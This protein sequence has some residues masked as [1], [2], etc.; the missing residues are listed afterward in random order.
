MNSNTL[1]E[2]PGFRLVEEPEKSTPPSRP[3][4]RRR[5]W[6]GLIWGEWFAHSRLLLAF[7][8][9]WLAAVWL[10]PFVAHPLWILMLSGLVAV[11]GGPAFGGSDVMGG[12]E[13][14]AFSQPT[15]RAQRFDARLL[16]AVGCLLT[17]TVMN[18]IALYHN[19]ADLILSF[20]VSTGLAAVELRHPELLYGVI[21]AVPLAAMAI[22]FSVAALA[23][24][25]AVAYT[26]WV[27]GALGALTGLRAGLSLEDFVWDRLNGRITVPLLLAVTVVILG[28][29]RKLYV[30]KEAG[31]ASSPLRLPLSG[32]A[33]LGAA[34]LGALGVAL[35]ITWFV[36]NFG[37]FW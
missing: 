8:V 28:I 5:L 4:R 1:S 12:C 26:A 32:W 31:R 2:A 22:G 20:F 29:T 18:V 33:T 37:R 27:W 15:T 21:F 17:V 13:E 35:L 3:S 16:V 11:V 30:A 19:L 6:V 25:R 14:F 24:T 36:T 34:A 7:L 10:L 9:L 23:T